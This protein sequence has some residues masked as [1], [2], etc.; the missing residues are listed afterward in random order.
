MSREQWWL[1]CWITAHKGHLLRLLSSLGDSALYLLK[2]ELKVI[3][4]FGQLVDAVET[5]QKTVN[6]GHQAV[7][8]MVKVKT[9]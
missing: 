1:R 3:Y 7:H 6:T 9:V 5:C 8:I 4:F 2:L